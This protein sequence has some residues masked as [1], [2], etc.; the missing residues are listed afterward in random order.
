ML[1]LLH[2]DLLQ[3]RADVDALDQTEDL[4]LQLLVLLLV[5]LVLLDG[6][7]VLALQDLFLLLQC[8]LLRA[9]LR[10]FELLADDVLFVGCPFGF[11]LFSLDVQVVQ[12]LLCIDLQIE[13]VLALFLF[14]GELFG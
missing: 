14:F 9:Q 3:Q 1:H 2:V 6:D 8:L 10:Q 13:H 12:G 4:F 5:L 7:C 11:H